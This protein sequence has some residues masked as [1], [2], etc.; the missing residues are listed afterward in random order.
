MPVFKGQGPVSFKA[1][2]DL[3]TKQY[4]AVI[5]STVHD[6]V[7]VAGANG[8][9]IG[10]LINAPNSGEEALVCLPGSICPVLLGETLSAQALLTPTADGTLEQVDAAGE[11]ISAVLLES[12]SSGEVVTALVTAAKSYASDA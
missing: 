6:E 12:G 2:A 9:S 7:N 1:A 8:K 4:C 10:I 11:W 3:R 5:A